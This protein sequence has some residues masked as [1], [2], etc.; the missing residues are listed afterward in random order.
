MTK[1]LKISIVVRAYNEEKHLPKLLKALD[2]Q[3]L[4]E[5][6]VILVDS[7]SQDET[8]K[9][10]KQ[11]GAKIVSILKEDFSFGRAI[12]VGCRE[13][14]GDILLFASAHVYPEFDDWLQRIADEF[15]DAQVGLVYGRQRA[16]ETNKFSEGVLMKRW[17]PDVSVQHQESAF[18]N[19][20][21]CA[22]RR[23]IWMQLPYDEDITGLEDL[24][25]A[26]VVKS[27]GWQI[28]YNHEASIIHTHEE[29]WKQIYNRY[30]REAMA[31]SVI[32]PSIRM[33][34]LDAF[35]LFYQNSLNDLRIA[36][37]ARLLLLHFHEIIAFRFLQFL[38]SWRGLKNPKTLNHD[39]IKRFY[40]PGKEK[41]CG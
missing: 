27:W 18:C 11:N 7:G 20:A 37:K 9:I 33:S 14:N 41:D 23:S 22:V 36:L 24:S 1:K 2:Q 17:F 4:R 6:E 21:N 12:N 29:T 3:T 13:A 31:L 5:F 15:K 19:N 16:G 38:G 10:A 26:K 25:W 28:N 8:V 32:D 30:L 34:L 39:L 35:K 40:Y